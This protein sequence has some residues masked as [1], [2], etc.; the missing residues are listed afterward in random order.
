[1]GNDGISLKDSGRL[2]DQILRTQK[3]TFIT[4]TDSLSLTLSLSLSLTHTH[5]LSRHSPVHVTFQQTI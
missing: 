1:M 3:A 2:I 4:P 5:T